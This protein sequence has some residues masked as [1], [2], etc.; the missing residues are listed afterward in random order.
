MGYLQE[1]WLVY[2]YEAPDHPYRDWLKFLKKG[3]KHC[4]VL[5][6]NP[7]LKRWIHLEWTHAGIRH[8][9]L[10]NDEVTRIISYMSNYEIVKCPVRNNWH[11]LRIKD[12]TCVT[13]VM[14]LIGFYKW[15]IFTPYQLFCALRKAGYSS[16]YKTNGQK[17]EKTPRTDNR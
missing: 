10:H 11:L 8:T 16:F 2:F 12:F 14:R 15:Y 13:F 17:K 3:F 6:F 7:E 4:G 9:V 5:G 1:E